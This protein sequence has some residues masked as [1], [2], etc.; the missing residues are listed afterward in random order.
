MIVVDNLSKQ[1]KLSKQQKREMGA[2]FTG[3]TVDAVA[4]ISFECKP[5]RIFSLLGP[6]GAGKT[7]TLRLISTMLRPSKGSIT[8]AGHDVARE[9]QAVRRKLGFLTGSTKLYDRLTAEEVVRYYADLH[10]M[11]K[12]TYQRRRDDIFALLDM[13][14]FAGRR[15]A[16]LSTGMKQ[17]VSIAR[18]VIHDPDVLVFDEA[19]SGLDVVASRGIVD[20]IR[21][22]RD[23]GKTVLFSTHRMGEVSQLSDDLA[24]I[25]RGQLLYNDTY[26][27]FTQQM[28]AE[29]FEDEFIRY[30]ETA[31]AAS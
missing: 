13:E 6:N 12:A 15:V 5:G 31:G 11:D 3:D 21:R 28:Q 7:T 2:S 23:D 4:S 19:T 9:P 22:S 20:L 10:G 17:K 16:K 8:V 1:F 29:S 14:S 27:A 24:I 18:T 30:I 26:E 25:H